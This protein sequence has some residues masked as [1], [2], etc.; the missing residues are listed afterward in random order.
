MASATLTGN[1]LQSSRAGSSLGATRSGTPDSP[2]L[3]RS[4]DFRAMS[5]DGMLTADLPWSRLQFVPWAKNPREV[6]MGAS[7]H[8]PSQRSH[9]QSKPGSAKFRVVTAGVALTTL[10]L[11][12]SAAQ[13]RITRLE[14]TRVE[15]P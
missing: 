6:L 13:A 3:A 12:T 4:T 2:S 14:I 9:A 1:S 10:A 7:H 15:S 11:A 5:L 8:R